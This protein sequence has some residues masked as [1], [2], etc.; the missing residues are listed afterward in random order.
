MIC[1]Y[2]IEFL[3]FDMHLLLM[4]FMENYSMELSTADLLAGLSRTD[5]CDD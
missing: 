2:Q 4:R 1:S 3:S 5:V